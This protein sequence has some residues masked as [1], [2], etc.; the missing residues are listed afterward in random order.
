MND[1]TITYNINR[2]CRFCLSE[3]GVM[4]T[5]FDKEIHGSAVPLPVKIMMCVLIQ[6]DVEDG[7]PSLICHRCLYQMER[8]Y[9]FKIQCENSDAKLRQYINRIKSENVQPRE[10][11]GMNLLIRQ[12]PQLRNVESLVVNVDPSEVEV[13]NR[14]IV[15]TNRVEGDEAPSVIEIKL[16]PSLD[17]SP[18]DIKQEI[19]TPN[20]PL[21]HMGG[22]EPVRVPHRPHVCSLCGKGFAQRRELTR[23]HMV[24]SGEKPFSC[25]VCGKKFARRDKVVSHLRIHGR[26]NSYNCFQCPAMFICREEL[27][28]HEM[29][30]MGKR[31]WHC[32][33]CNK[34]FCSKADLMKHRKTHRCDS[35][36]KCHLCSVTYTQ[37][38]NLLRHLKLHAE[39]RLLYNPSYSESDQSEQ[40]FLFQQEESQSDAFVSENQ[41]IRECYL[42]GTSDE[43]T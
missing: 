39:S 27:R 4:S 5:I 3:S 31:P 36:Y 24:H 30:H 11:N 13:E 17:I 10:S 9:E 28:R 29:D 42:D 16:P 15:L 1:D 22:S 2:I 37:H 41:D 25:P 6:V 20:S 43:V 35:L 19:I 32:Q 40:P 12:R 14:T 23:H 34:T 7:M 26:Q 8:S 18:L 21:N 38:E 33:K